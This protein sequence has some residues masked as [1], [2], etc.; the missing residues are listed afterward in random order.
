MN[1]AYHAIE[2][3]E[4][5]RDPPPNK[6]GYKVCTVRTLTVFRNPDF[7]ANA[8]TQ[9]GS[10]SCPQAREHPEHSLPTK[11]EGN[12]F[13]S[14]VRSGPGRLQGSHDLCTVNRQTQHVIKSASAP[15]QKWHADP[16][17]TVFDAAIHISF[18]LKNISGSLSRRLRG[19]FIW[20]KPISGWM[21]CQLALDSFGS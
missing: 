3:R 11:V 4:G 7:A 18:N 16:Q 10:G 12:K 17:A 5:E 8:A 6:R 13:G 9:C 14:I 20:M 2:Q 21:I 19:P 1:N 15:P